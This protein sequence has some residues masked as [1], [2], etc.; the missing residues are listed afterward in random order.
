MVAVV[1]YGLTNRTG[2]KDL[3]ELFVLG[4]YAP[5]NRNGPGIWLR[6]VIAG[7]VEGYTDL[8]DADGAPVAQRTT[9]IGGGEE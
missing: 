7:K 9:V 2:R 3:P 5:E 8:L 4:N 1:R 6:C